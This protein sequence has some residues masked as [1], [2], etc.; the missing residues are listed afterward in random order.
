MPRHDEGGGK[1]VERVE[2]QQIAGRAFLEALT[3]RDF[4]GVEASLDPDIRFRGLLP[5]GLHELSGAAAVAD[6]L[7]SWFEEADA[8]E[9]EEIVAEDIAD[10]LRISYRFRLHDEDG[11]A[12]IEQQ[13]FC[14]VDDGRIERIDL[15]CSGFRPVAEPEA[16]DVHRFDAGE[17]GCADG[18]AQEF[19]RRIRAIPVGDV[20]VV[21]AGDPAAKEELPSMAR[22]LGN[23]VRS[24]ESLDDGRLLITVERVK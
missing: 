21:A 16:G 18:L 20:L 17:L 12:V 19:R 10:R 8:F 5:S 11:W 22:L 9:V 3:S 15:V 1:G 14:D 7:R 2:G 4:E 13:A 6:Q 23:T 24:V